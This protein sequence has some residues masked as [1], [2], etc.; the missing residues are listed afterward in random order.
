MPLSFRS[1]FFFS[2]HSQD[3][4]FSYGICHPRDQPTATHRSATSHSICRAWGNPRAEDSHYLR[5]PRI[6]ACRRRTAAESARPK[7]KRLSESHGRLRRV[8]RTSTLE[9]KWLRMLCESVGEGTG[10][11]Q[12]RICKPVMIIYSTCANTIACHP[13][14]DS[15]CEQC[16]STHVE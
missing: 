14:I 9:P 8:P 5:L 2:Q 4:I 12:E 11:V 7:D 10:T 15:P 1:C 6:P 3:E 13:L 16:S